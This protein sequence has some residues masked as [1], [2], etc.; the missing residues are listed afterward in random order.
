M[1]VQITGSAKGLTSAYAKAGAST[2]RFGKAIDKVNGR[3]RAVQASAMGAAR[4]FGAFLGVAGTFGAIGFVIKTA[5]DMEET[6]NKFNVV[7]GDSADRVK[8]FS[9]A[10]AKAMG[11]SK[12][13][14]ATFMA[15]AQDL[16]VPL[17][18]AATE[19]E[20]MSTQM[21]KL[22]IDLASFNI[23]SDEDVFRDLS[24]ALTGSGEVM[25]KYGVIVS[26]AAVKQELLNQ[27]IDPKIA[28]NQQK[29]Q[30]RMN[31]IMRG[32]IAAQGD[33]ARSLDSFANSAK[34][35]KADVSDLS[36]QIGRALL[37]AFTMTVK[38]LQGV[39]KWLEVNGK[40]MA[41]ATVQVLAFAAGWTAIVLVLPKVWLA[42][43]TT[44]LAIKSLTIAVATGQAVSGVGLVKVAAGLAAAAGMAV[45][46]GNMFDD[47]VGDFDSAQASAVKTS[48]AVDNVAKSLKT[49]AKAPA[50]K[51]GLGAAPDVGAARAGTMAG[52]SAV[53]SG[54]KELRRMLKLMTDAQKERK[55][56]TDV[57]NDISVNTADKIVVNQANI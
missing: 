48:K 1:S 14:I 4:G 19:A 35:L 23:M 7:F 54:K 26:E 57:L 6:M 16:F 3:L 40:A 27:K 38:K 37:P 30:A 10:I 17:G 33:V 32:T 15:S 36:A 52:F 34:K 21:T 22:S 42:I 25:K 51:I 55:K 46:A 20:A 12:L 8:T 49:V 9:D 11:R 39:V 41:R 47:L 45:F 31:I 2:R 56:Q 18:F 24:A 50:V 5:S 53:H 28:T 44:I 29:V 43:R 13:Q